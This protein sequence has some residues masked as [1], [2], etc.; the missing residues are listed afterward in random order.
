MK[1]IEVN[2]MF[3]LT[4]SSA[5]LVAC[6]NEFSLTRLLNIRSFVTISEVNLEDILHSL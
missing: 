2:F 1:N 5:A 3:L 6:E 4:R